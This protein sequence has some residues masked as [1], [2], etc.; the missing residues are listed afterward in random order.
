MTPGRPPPRPTAA[1]RRLPPLPE[2]DCELELTEGRTAR[3]HLPPGRPLGELAPL[4]VFLHGAGG[5]DRPLPPLLLA[6]ADAHGL[7]VLAPRSRGWTWDFVLGRLGP[8]LDDLERALEAVKA[9][10]PVDPSRVA[11][12]GF[13]DGASYAL[14]VALPNRAAFSHAIAFSPGFAGP[15]RPPQP[16]VFIAHGAHDSVLPVENARAIAAR[17]RSEGC[18]VSF[19]EFDG[20]HEVPPAV[21]EEAIRW[22]LGGSAAAR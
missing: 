9:R 6:L 18:E 7:V 1:S 14:T 20:G 16:A 2:G 21:A 5:S 11:L 17:L 22:F 12:A 13:S 8:D 10:A 19:R 15:S 4:V 3:V